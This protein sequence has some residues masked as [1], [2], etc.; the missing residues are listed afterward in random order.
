MAL[1][2]ANSTTLQHCLL[3]IYILQ[4]YEVS[5]QR[6]I[7]ASRS[8]FSSKIYAVCYL[9]FIVSSLEGQQRFSVG[10]NPGQSTERDPKFILSY[11]DRHLNQRQQIIAGHDDSLA[12][13]ECFAPTC[14][15]V[16]SA[17][18]GTNN[19]HSK[20]KNYSLD[21]VFKAFSTSTRLF[22]YFCFFH[23]NSLSGTN[24]LSKYINIFY[25]F[26]AH[27]SCCSPILYTS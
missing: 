26:Y 4:Q 2:D 22:I 19:R 6:T 3:H 16:F 18:V 17:L 5:E 7:A 25:N 27:Q 20:A 15:R 13:A 10:S 12:F 11:V 9:T 24:P 8:C 1:W 23:L 14:N 21:T